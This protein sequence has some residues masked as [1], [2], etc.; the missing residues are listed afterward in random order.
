MGHADLAPVKSQEA[1]LEH[2]P[3]VVAEKPQ[4]Q[5]D[6]Q[7]RSDAKDVAVEGGMVEGAQGQAI[8]YDGLATRVA[9]R[10]DVGS[11]Q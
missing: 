7:I 10:Q 11:G 5:L 2:R 4:T 9:I 6:R 8:G 1:V 3:I